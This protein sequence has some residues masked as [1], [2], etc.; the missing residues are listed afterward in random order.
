MVTK[1]LASFFLDISGISFLQRNEESCG[2]CAIYE[3]I[4]GTGGRI[5]L[6]LILGPRWR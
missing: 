4:G 6:I 2:S 1:L 5:P 3:G